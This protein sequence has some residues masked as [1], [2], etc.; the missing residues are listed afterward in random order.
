MSTA[1]AGGSSSGA[2]GGSTAGSG[3]SGSRGGSA[4]SGSG[5]SGSSPAGSAAAATSTAAGPAGAASSGAEAEHGGGRPGHY[6]RLVAPS[7]RGELASGWVTARNTFMG[8]I[9]IENVTFAGTST[10]ELSS[11][12]VSDLCALHQGTP[13]VEPPG[14]R[15]LCRTLAVHPIVVCGGPEGCGK[16][17]AVARACEFLELPRIRLLPS[18]LAIG[19]VCRTAERLAQQ[20]ESTTLVLTGVDRDRLRQLAGPPGT[21]IRALAASGRVRLVVTARTVDTTAFP[22]A[23]LEAPDPARV[24]DANLRERGWS[25]DAAQICADVLAA[26]E[27]PVGPAVAADVV[28]QV[29]SREGSDRDKVLSDLSILYSRHNTASAAVSE[30]LGDGRSPDEV[31]VLAVAASLAGLPA[32]DVQEHVAPLLRLLRRDRLGAEPESRMRSHAMWPEQFIRTKVERVATEFGPHEVPVLQAAPPFRAEDI[33]LALWDALGERF[34]YRYCEWLRRLPQESRLVWYAGQTAGTLFSAHPAQ[35]TSQVLEPWARSDEDDDRYCAGLALGTPVALGKNATA[36]RTLADYWSTTEGTARK[37]AA[38]AAYAGLLGAVGE[39]SEAVLK[40]FD[41]GERDSRLARSANWG[42]ANL[43]AS[44]RDRSAARSW[45]LAYLDRLSQ[46]RRHRERAFSALP[47]V[48][49]LLTQSEPTCVDSYRALETETENWQLLIGLL[50]RCLTQ[51]SGMAF[52]RECVELA[53]GAVVDGNVEYTRAE[54]LLGAVARTPTPDVDLIRCRAVLRTW[55]AAIERAAAQRVREA[56]QS[57]TWILQEEDSDEYE[58]RDE[59]EFLLADES[60]GGGSIRST[61]TRNI[62]RSLR[63]AV[64]SEEGTS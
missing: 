38:V 39:T 56:S 16:E 25:D 20:W 31:A 10:T 41:I 47:W 54:R 15:D 50:A 18:G 57:E 3:A 37:H 12:P 7:S 6:A 34:Q 40:L 61:A 9:T 44:G 64:S 62:A 8:N 53:V 24:L 2:A 55:L 26:L 36:A 13:F 29:I 49:W 21:P 51:P 28:R 27:P 14:Y 4:G 17:L 11:V 22:V 48:I 35:I 43:I 52:G 58:H 59:Q 60:S 5:P 42:W 19:D 63:Q 45:V 46:Q 32:L 1:T 30:W 23:P 33:V